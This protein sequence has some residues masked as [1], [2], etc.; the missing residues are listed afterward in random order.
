[1][2]G[3]K[4]NQTTFSKKT[5]KIYMPLN[6]GVKISLASGQLGGT[7][8]TNDGIVGMILT[9]ATETIAGGG[10]TYTVGTPILVTSLKNL[11]AQGIS[12]VGNPFAYRQ[13]KEFYSEAGEGAQLYL[14]LLPKTESIKDMLDYTQEGNAKALVGLS[15]GKIKVLGAMTD[16]AAIE[17][18]SPGTIDI[19]D[20]LNKLV[21][22]ALVTADNLTTEYFKKQMPFR[23]IIG[24]TSYTNETTDLNDLTTY[25]YNRAA[26]LLGDTEEGDGTYCAAALGLALGRIAAIPVQR[27]ISRVEDGPL[28][29]TTAFL[30]DAAVENVPDDLPLIEEKGF[31]TWKS[32]PHMS[33]YFFSGDDTCSGTDDD[34]HQLARGRVIDKAHI[35]TYL[36]YVNEVDNEIPTIEGGLPEPGWAKGMEQLIINQLN[37]TMVANRECSAVQCQ[38]PLDQDVI[39]NGKVIIKPRI[40]PV[41]YARFID[42]ELGFTL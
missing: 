36:T 4:K 34:Y 29:I 40:R 20:G 21:Y 27:M 10:A 9:G 24:G 22:E 1:L 14:L 18:T 25:N 8:Q 15:Q 12:A 3:A 19:E 13:V 28:G 17:A 41:G 37:Q 11:A 23:V 35:L 30:N 32:F 39:S 33:G 2:A 42:I 5:K 31:I 26:I 7:I 16:D 6:R 38:V